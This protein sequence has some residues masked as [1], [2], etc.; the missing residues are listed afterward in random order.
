MSVKARILG[1]GNPL[2]G[3][4]GVGVAVV[5]HLRACLLPADVE[6]VDGGLGGMALLDC[7]EGVS[8]VILVDA[9]DFGGEPG[10]FRIL[11]LHDLPLDDASSLQQLHAG[12]VPLLELVRQL[13]LC[14]HVQLV[15]V[16]GM[17]TDAPFTLSPPVHKAVPQVAEAV[18]SLL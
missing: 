17:D 2:R 16:Q 15:A 11:D 7:F 9:A 12:I 6:V 14:P 8:R 3:D 1:I 18:L 5:E 10:A 13:E 4:D